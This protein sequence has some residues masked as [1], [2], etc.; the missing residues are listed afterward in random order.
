MHRD[1][2]ELF[3]QRGDQR[4]NLD[5]WILPEQMQR[6][7]AVFAARPGKGHAPPFSHVTISIG[8]L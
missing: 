3:I 5:A 2:I 1:A 8:Q 6:P 4:Y 7:S